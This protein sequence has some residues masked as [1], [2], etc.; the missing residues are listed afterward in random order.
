[1][2]SEAKAQW[3]GAILDT[4]SVS[5]FLYANISDIRN[6]YSYGVAYGIIR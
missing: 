2:W 5:Y 4:D 6:S 1:M 3:Y